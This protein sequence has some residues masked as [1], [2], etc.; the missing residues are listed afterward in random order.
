M[1]IIISDDSVHFAYLLY[2]CKLS[3]FTDYLNHSVT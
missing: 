2:P 1:K 3:F